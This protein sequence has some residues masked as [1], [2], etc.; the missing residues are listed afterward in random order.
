MTH[1]AISV[2][3]PAGIGPDVTLGALENQVSQDLL[4]VA[5]AD[6]L[7]TRARMLNMAM[8]FNRISNPAQFPDQVQEKKINVLHT[9]LSR[10]SEPGQLDPSNSG[11]VLE[12][13]HRC[14]SLC[15]EGKADAMVTAPVHKGIINDAGHAFSGHTEL[16]AA[17]CN[18]AKPVMMLASE[19]MKVCLATTHLPI[20]KVSQALNQDMLIETIRIIN[21]DLK[22]LYN[23]ERPTI[24]VCGLNPHAGEGGHLG[25]EE[26]TIIEPAIN[27]LR[28]EGKDIVGPLP[29]DTAFA[30]H[31]LRQL[32]AV[33]AMF[34]DQ[35]LPVIK[36]NDF[37]DT[38]NITLGL[39]I[40]RTSVD[41]GTAVDL[42]ATGRANSQ[43]MSAAIDK[44]RQFVR[45][46]AK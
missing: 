9:P 46:I 29:A 37:G 41:H 44:A 22:R 40:I 42:A 24:G 14:V 45:N 19:R 23:I 1:I 25:D 35:G 3:E 4:L 27:A 38:V 20:V 30:P 39:P 21:D 26:I 32:D 28:S 12:C 5:D 15:Q 8:D 16:I 11:Y 43:S 18:V 10:E 6:M 34:H 31:Q 2:G 13:I 17:L 7:E 36:H 33:L